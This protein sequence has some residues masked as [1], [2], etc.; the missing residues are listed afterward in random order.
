MDLNGVKNIIFDLGGVIINLNQDLTYKGFQDLFPTQ[1]DEIQDELEKSEI[2]NRFETGEVAEDD[3]ISFFSKYNTEI[4]SD[5]LKAAWN[6]MLLDIPKER[7]ELIIKLSSTYNIYLLSNTN[8]IHLKAIDDYVIQNFKMNQLDELF[9]KAYYSHKI[10][11]RKPNKAIFEYVLNDGNLKAGETLFIDDS[12]EHIVSAKKL[13]I[14][15]HHLDLKANQTLTQL[16][17]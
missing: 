2:L 14:I 13:G 11:L 12:Q 15:T 6:N 3:F 16:F 17:K 5:N 1:F 10:K 7:I 9:I 4:T 8:P